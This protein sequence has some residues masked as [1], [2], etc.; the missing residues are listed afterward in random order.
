MFLF[1][2]ANDVFASKSSFR[3]TLK[4]LKCYAVIPVLFK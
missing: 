1:F 2:A 4:V 3:L